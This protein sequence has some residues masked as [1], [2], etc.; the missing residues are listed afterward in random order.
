M[1]IKKYSVEIYI[2]ITIIF[3]LLYSFDPVIYPDSGRYL[4]ES[5][6]D[7][8]LYSL[9]IKLFENIFGSLKSVIIFQTLFIAFGIIYLIKTLTLYLD[10]DFLT[11]VITA[12]FLLLPI[13]KFYN[14]LLT[15]P[16]GYA[17]SLLFV[18]FV[19]KSIYNF[20]NQNLIGITIFGILLLLLRTQFIFLYPVILFVYTGIYILNNS[21]KTSIWL[22]ISFVSIILIHNS[23][24]SLNKYIKKMDQKNESLHSSKQYY[25]A[26]RMLSN[27]TIYVSTTKDIELFENEDL[28]ETLRNI[29]IELNKK[30]LLLKYN[31]KIRGHF[32]TGYPILDDYTEAQLI[33]LITE[34][35]GTTKKFRKEIFITLVKENYV[36]Y[37]KLLFKKMYD[38]TW[39]FVTLPALIFITSFI[40]FLKQ[41]SHFSLVAIFLSIFTL[42]N[43]SIVYLFGRV[44]PR[45]FIYTDFVLLVFIFITLTIL[46]K[47]NKLK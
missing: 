27:D 5:L 38:S 21:K 34:K 33:D 31:K 8:P 20:N 36:Q 3:L 15:E 22:I 24:I 32:S 44:Q 39:L 19:I 28:K 9:I 4:N 7:P 30:K 2:L 25:G 16:L 17:F 29:Y 23:T 12:T 41:K 35:N 26:F 43:H 45:Y 10:I 6:K 1:I 18:S 14:I 47:K 46:Y 13:A 40:Y 42:G 37:I 11:K